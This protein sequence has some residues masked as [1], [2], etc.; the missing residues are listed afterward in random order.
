M[1]KLTI[2]FER[3]ERESVFID[4]YRRVHMPLARELPGLVKSEV[5]L[6]S[7]GSNGDEPRFCLMTELYFETEDAWRLAME[8]EQGLALV[9]DG[10]NF[11]EGTRF[12]GVVVGS[13][14]V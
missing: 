7:K 5:T 13:V 11:P 10:E 8:S 6:F 3:F 14:I 9:A 2:F 1:F 12:G 4:Y